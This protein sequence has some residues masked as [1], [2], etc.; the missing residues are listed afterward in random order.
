MAET[1]KPIPIKV[2]IPEHLRSPGVANIIRVTTAP[3]GEVIID[4]I[5]THPQ[6]TSP[7]GVKPGVLVSRILLPKATARDLQIILTNHLGKLKTE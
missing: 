5:F 2:T 1:N 3:S 4:F 6:D 7:D